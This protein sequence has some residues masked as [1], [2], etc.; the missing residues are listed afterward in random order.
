MWLLRSRGANRGRRED[1]GTKRRSTVST[2]KYNDSAFVLFA[3]YYD[4]N[5]GQEWVQCCG[6]CS[7]WLHEKC[8]DAI[9]PF[10]QHSRFKMASSQEQAQVV[11]EF[12][13]F[14][15][16]KLKEAPPHWS[17][18]VRKRRCFLDDGWKEE[19]QYSGHQHL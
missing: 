9:Y 4:E 7:S 17:W 16:Q 5:Q 14:N 13:E 8:V 1:V 10:F 3:N 2:N 19:L 6:L 11:E 15:M 18:K 12:I